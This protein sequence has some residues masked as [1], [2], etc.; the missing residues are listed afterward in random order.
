MQRQC[1]FIKADKKRCRGFCVADTDFCIYH[2]DDPAM[3]KKLHDARVKGGI[4]RSKPLATLPV[5]T[6]DVELLTSY[7]VRAFIALTLNQVRRGQISVPIG[8]C[9]FVGTGVLL[10]AI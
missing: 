9:L 1:T 3:K 6:P 2:C 5:D 10:R 7:D 8:N 4:E